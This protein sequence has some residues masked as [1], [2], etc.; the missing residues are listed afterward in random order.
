MS[1]RLLSNAEVNAL[2]AFA[3]DHRL[4][5]VTTETAAATALAFWLQN[6]A[7]IEGLYGD[8]TQEN[9][10][11]ADDLHRDFAFL[12]VEVVNPVKIL[13]L[14][15]T[16]AYQCV[17]SPGWEGSPSQALLREIARRADRMASE[18][19]ASMTPDA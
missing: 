19:P 1:S 18:I 2:A 11:R 12:I 5:G 16:Y 9:R 3:A 17:S 14:T 8:R 4:G 13:A 7:G 6:L 15:Q 10:P